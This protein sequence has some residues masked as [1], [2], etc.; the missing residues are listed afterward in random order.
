MIPKG[1]KSTERFWGL[2]MK[3]K[4]FVKILNSDLRYVL[5]F[6]NVQYTLTE[7]VDFD[8]LTSDSYLE[9]YDDYYVTHLGLDEGN[10]IVYL[11]TIDK[12][13]KNIESEV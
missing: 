10:V 7:Y 6:E 13:V 5:I 11:K 8:E 1:L 9:N 3:L 12:I 4:D 2:Y